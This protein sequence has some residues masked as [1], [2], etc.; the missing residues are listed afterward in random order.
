[1]FVYKTFNEFPSK[2]SKIICISVEASVYGHGSTATGAH[3]I[4]SG[5]TRVTKNVYIYI[6]ILIFLNILSKSS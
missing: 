1:M 4:L 3:D 5:D 6:Y 2:V